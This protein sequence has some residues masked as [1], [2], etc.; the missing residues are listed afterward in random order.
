MW[1]NFPRLLRALLDEPFAI[2]ARQGNASQDLF[3]ADQI[4]AG[5][6]GKGLNATQAA[7]SPPALTTR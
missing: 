7:T 2:A 4:S 6:I 3:S 1:Q 5:F